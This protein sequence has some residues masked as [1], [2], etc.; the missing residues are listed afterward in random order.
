MEKLTKKQIKELEEIKNE[1]RRN[2][3]KLIES[4]KNYKLDC[5]AL[6]RV[7]QMNNENKTDSYG[8]LKEEES[9]KVLA[10]YENLTWLIGINW[11]EN[12]SWS[13]VRTI[14]ESENIRDSFYSQNSEYRQ[15]KE[16][17]KDDSV[18]IDDIIWSHEE[19]TLFVKILKEYGIDYIYYTDSST[20]CLENITS[21]H[22]LGAKIIDTT[23]IKEEG[24]GL[25]FDISNATT[26]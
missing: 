22:I 19:M 15:A 17:L 4:V 1:K 11:R 9:E 2:R 13:V 12:K 24:K 8:D 21:L 18:W 25:V 10:T 20:A 3:R 6:A 26:E 23:N 7:S 14:V 16:Y 5:K